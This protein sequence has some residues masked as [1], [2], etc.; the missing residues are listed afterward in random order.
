MWRRGSSSS[1]LATSV[2]TAIRVKGH[3][4]STARFRCAT[5]GQKSRRKRADAAS[6]SAHQLGTHLATRP[7]VNARD[8]F[9]ALRTHL[10]AARAALDGGDRNRALAEVTA[11]LD[12]DPNYLAAHSLRDR[13]LSGDMSIDVPPPAGPAIEP[14]PAAVTAPPPV[15]EGPLVSQ[16]PFVSQEGYA[17]FEQRAKRRRVDRRIDAARQ[18]IERKHLKQAAAALDEVIELDPNLPE[19]S[20]LTVEFDQ[21]RRSAIRSTHRGPWL[22]AAAVFAATVF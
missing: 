16:G 2:W 1:G 19:L 17:K 4:C 15:A 5:R 11:A 10:I 9:H 13:I 18:A 20:D 12:L 14:A 7:R 21:L 3:S 6:S 22:A 8:Q